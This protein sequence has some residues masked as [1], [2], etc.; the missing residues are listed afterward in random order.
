LLLIGTYRPVEVIVRGH[1][2][3]IIKQEL[4]LHRR[5]EALPL[6]VLTEADVAQYL[7]ARLAGGE[8]QI[9][10]LPELARA[11]HRSTDGHPLFMVTMVDYLTRQGW[12]T[13]IVGRWQVTAGLAEIERGCRQRGVC[14]CI[15]G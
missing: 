3:K 5:C 10:P 4:Q 2:L 15:G 7:V 9:S 11:I 12:V 8:P 14:C 6:E 13:A 1:P